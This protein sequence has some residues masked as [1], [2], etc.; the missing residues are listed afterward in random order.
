M[1]QVGFQYP[2]EDVRARYY[3]YVHQTY[4]VGPPWWKSGY[5]TSELV[6]AAAARFSTNGVARQG[7]FDIR[8]LGALH[9]LIFGGLGLLLVGSRALRP[10]ARVGFAAPAVRV[11]RCGITALDNSFYSGRHPSSSSSCSR[12]S[13]CASRA[14]V[15]RARCAPDTGS[16][17]SPS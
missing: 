13:Y 9:A 6:L 1:G 4:D 12:E 14:D 17:P 7:T 8:A 11:H 16:P 10:G 5:R 2:T 3:G 15:A